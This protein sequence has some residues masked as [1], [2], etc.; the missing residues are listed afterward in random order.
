M[1]RYWLLLILSCPLLAWGKTGHRVIAALAERHLDPHVH[2]R[3]LDL[4]DGRSLADIANWSDDVRTSQFSTSSWHYEKDADAIEEDSASSLYGVV[5]NQ[6][7][8][9]EHDQDREKRHQALKWVV[10]LV[11]DMHQPLHIGNGIDRGGNTCKVY[12]FSNRYKVNLHHVWDTLL[13]KHTEYS[14]QEYVAYLD[15]IGID[16]VKQWQASDIV[17]WMKESRALHDEIYPSQYPRSNYCKGYGT[18]EAS[19][20]RYP[21]LSHAYIQRV[22]PILEQRLQQASIRLAHLLNQIFRSAKT[23]SVL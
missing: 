18:V 6:L 13:I 21:R 8:I 3:V 11:A 10:H 20:K 1:R 9:L 22:T 12:W 5:L 2:Q 23:H 17:D 16:L 14:Y 4:N 15:H 7:D 19:E